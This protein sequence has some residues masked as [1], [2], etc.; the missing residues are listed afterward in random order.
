MKTNLKTS[1]S[2]AFSALSALALAAPAYATDVNLD[3][4][5][6]TPPPWN[7][8]CNINKDNL[9]GVIGTIIIV[10][11]IGAALVAL[12]F[13]IWGGIKWIMSGGDKGKVETARSTIIAALI[14]LVITFLAFFL[15]SFI[16]SIFGLS[17]NNLV[18]PN[19]PTS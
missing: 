14:G 12:F 1:L 18:I 17:I 19:L 16:L 3:P 7:S 9:P 6:A 8:L 13:L 5:A 15:L 11:F 10:L 2:T 4:C